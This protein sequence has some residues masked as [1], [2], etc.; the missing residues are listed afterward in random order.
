MHSPVS[1]KITEPGVFLISF[2]HG[3]KHAHTNTPDKLL[4]QINTI[5]PAASGPLNWN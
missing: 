5:D 1:L 4:F 3:P 2:T